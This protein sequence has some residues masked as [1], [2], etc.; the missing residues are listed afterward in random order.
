MGILSPVL[1]SAWFTN[2]PLLAIVVWGKKLKFK[3][4]DELFKVKRDK[5]SEGLASDNRK[6][7]GQKY[8]LPSSLNELYSWLN[9]R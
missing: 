9:K 3:N 6:H 4:H 1:E 7:F 2:Y 8:V 5:K